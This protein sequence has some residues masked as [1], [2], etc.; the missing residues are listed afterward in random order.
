MDVSCSLGLTGPK[1]DEVTY[2][3]LD[4]P[5]SISINRKP[6]LLILCLDIWIFRCQRV[7]DL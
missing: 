2:I 6:P 1:E 7:L 5:S 3:I 4:F